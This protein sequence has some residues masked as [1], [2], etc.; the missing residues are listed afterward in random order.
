MKVGD[1]VRLNVHSQFVTGIN[2][3]IG[4]P[5]HAIGVVLQSECDCVSVIFP[6]VEKEVRSFMREDLEIVSESQ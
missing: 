4:I 1:L 2:D 5:F 3:I 6:C